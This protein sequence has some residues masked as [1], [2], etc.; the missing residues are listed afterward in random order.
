MEYTQSKGNII[1]LRCI[2]KFIEYGIQCSIPY[3]NGAKYDFIADIEGQLLRIQCKS[4][5]LTKHGSLVFSCLSTTTNTQKTRQHKYTKQDID[6]FATEYQGEV[7]VIPVEKCLHCLKT[8]RLVPSQ[9]NNHNYENAADYSFDIFIHNYNTNIS[10][11]IF[12][13]NNLKKFYCSQ[14]G[15][16]EVKQEGRI[17]FRCRCLSMRKTQRPLREELKRLI[18]NNSWR[19]L[20]KRYGVSDKTIIKWCINYNLPFK[21]SEIKH[22]SD[23]EWDTI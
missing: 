12:N 1:E 6:Y 16:E 9:N 15:I 10:K 21:K 23:K 7:Y 17:C 19:D 13:H 18:R 20:S 11:I 22:M 14:C 3:G 5:T 4:S 2:T 8:L